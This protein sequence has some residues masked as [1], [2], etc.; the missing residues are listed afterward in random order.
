MLTWPAG[1]A[2]RA[3]PHNPSRLRRLETDPNAR[4]YME[5][6]PNWAN[7]ESVLTWIPLTVAN[8]AGG[9]FRLV[10]AGLSR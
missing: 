4:F 8:I 7:G 10:R 9:F 3:M 6:N 2:L 1:D 5:V